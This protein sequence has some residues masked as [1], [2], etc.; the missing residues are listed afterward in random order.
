VAV[1]VLP[2]ATAV[3]KRAERSAHR[4]Y[5]FHGVIESVDTAAGTMIVGVDGRRGATNRGARALRGRQVTVDVSS[6]RVKVRDANRD[7][8]ADLA[9][10]GAGQRVRVLAKGPRRVV[11]H[12]TVR[13]RAM[14]V[15]AVG[16]A[17]RRANRQ[18]GLNSSQADRRAPR[19][20]T[21]D[22]GD[23]ADEAADA[24]ETLEE[25]LD[26]RIDR[27][28]PSSVAAAVAAAVAAHDAAHPDE[29]SDADDPGDAV[30]DLA[31]A[32]PDPAVEPGEDG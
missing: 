19:P 22:H 8:L 31:D 21:G 1:A 16:K 2:T 25:D 7:G 28:L 27:G 20:S 10:I 13:L 29:A 11:A 12:T 26:R 17:P 3:A 24:A 6:A 4:T 15:T 9:D 23:Q 14:R 5:G 32:D 18:P 30:A